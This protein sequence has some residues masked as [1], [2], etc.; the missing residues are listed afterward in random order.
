MQGK[1]DVK[2]RDARDAFRNGHPKISRIGGRILEATEI[3]LRAVLFVVMVLAIEL[4][5]VGIVYLA[6]RR[7]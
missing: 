2:E 5:C 6:C 3:V 7:W 4:A 1:K